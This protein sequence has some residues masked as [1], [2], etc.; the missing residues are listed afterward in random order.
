MTLGT[1]TAGP[2]APGPAASPRSEWQVI[3]GLAK[4]AKPEFDGLAG[5]T[6]RE[7]LP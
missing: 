5:L 6:R 7:P 3:G 1:M 2:G 4:T